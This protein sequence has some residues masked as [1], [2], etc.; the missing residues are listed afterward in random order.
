MMTLASWLAHEETRDEEVNKVMAK[1]EKDP[2]YIRV[3]LLIPTTV[4]NNHNLISSNFDLAPKCITNQEQTILHFVDTFAMLGTKSIQDFQRRWHALP[5]SLQIREYH[6]LERLRNALER[7]PLYK[8]IMQR[9]N[10]KWIGL[11]L[12]PPLLLGLQEGIN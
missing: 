3:E 2:L 6:S 7:T 1:D 12:C 5:H 8:R 11:K 4:I 9:T 10:I